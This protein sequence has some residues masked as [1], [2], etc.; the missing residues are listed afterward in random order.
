MTSK[1][2][3]YVGIDLGGTFIKGGIVNDCGEI[4]ASDKIATESEKGSDGVSTNIASLAKMLLDRMELTVSD[5]VGVGL[6]C[7]GMIDSKN[8]NVIYSSNLNW[9][10]FNIC[11]AV[12]EK[13]GCASVKVANDANVA[14]L[15]EVK[16]GAAK[17]YDNAVMVTLGTGLGSGIVIDGVLMEGN[18]GAGAELGH[19]VIHRGGEQCSCGRRGCCEAYCSATALIRD[20][21]RAMLAH[22]DSKM[23][24]IGSADQVNGKTAF[25]YLES[26]KYAK[27]VVDNYI[28][29]L[30]CTLTNFANI[31]RPEIILLG[32]GVCAEGDRLILPLQAEVDKEIFAGEK[33]PAVPIVIAKLG[34]SAGLLGAAALFMN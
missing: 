31:F 30:A 6:G 14:A 29:N 2:K 34:N 18:K 4:L 20:T 17:D 11:S 3:Y 21:K 12:S 26:D 25:D 32:G 10:D 24:E 9:S 19:T 5:I 13:L 23:W 22:P 7:P 28:S 1:C 15:G 16:F 8:G 27:E 33:G